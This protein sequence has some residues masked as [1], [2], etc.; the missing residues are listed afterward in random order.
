VKWIKAG[1]TVLLAVLFFALAPIAR[2]DDNQGGD[3]PGPSVPEPSGALVMSV[4][5]GTA[6]LATRRL[7]P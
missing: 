3:G 4:A 7:R 1:I 5:L 6:L 2:A